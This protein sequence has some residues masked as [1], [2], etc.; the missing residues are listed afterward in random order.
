M[1]LDLD[2]ESVNM[3]AKIREERKILIRIQTRQLGDC[4]L[5]TLFP[6]PLNP[7]SLVV[8]EESLGGAHINDFVTSCLSVFAVYN[9]SNVFKMSLIILCYTAK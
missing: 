3:D 4:L 2:V 1:S 7:L 5:R 8:N 9:R 6:F